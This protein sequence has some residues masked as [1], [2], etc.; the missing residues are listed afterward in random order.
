MKGGGGEEKRVEAGLKK[1]EKYSQR[2]DD[3]IISLFSFIIIFSRTLVFGQISFY[4]SNIFSFYFR[5]GMMM[6]MQFFI[7]RNLIKAVRFRNKT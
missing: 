4:F 2:Y 6:L 5:P 7:L 3:V 1:K